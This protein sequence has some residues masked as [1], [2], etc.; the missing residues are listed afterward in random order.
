MGPIYHWLF[1]TAWIAFGMYWF[2]SAFQVKK[3]LRSE[4]LPTRIF[5]LALVYFTVFLAVRAGVHHGYFWHAPSRFS[6]RFFVGAI[7]LL[8]GLGFAVWA[9]VH[10]G[11]YWSGRVQ[12]KEGHRLIRTGPYQLVRHPIYTGILTGFL[13]TVVAVGNERGMVG[14][15]LLTVLFVLKSRREERL[16][17]SAFGEEYI[18]YRK[19]VPAFVP[20]L[21]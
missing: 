16:M 7:L 9:R 14:F 19:H 12:L 13:G 17:I 8:A 2:V 11:E 1:P 6:L 3:A 5:Y 15:L 4:S 18:E 10:L 21:R 20:F